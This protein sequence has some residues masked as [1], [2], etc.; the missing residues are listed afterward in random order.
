MAFDDLS[1]RQFGDLL[2]VLDDGRDARGA[3]KWLCLCKC[4]TQVSVWAQSLRS[5]RTSRCRNCR[6]ANWNKGGH[7][8]KQGYHVRYTEGRGQ[9]MVHVL[10][11]EE[12]LGRR[13]LPGENVHH[14]NGVKDDNRP[15]NLELWVSHQPA[16]QRPEDL[17]AWAKE[18]LERYDA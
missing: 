2:V 10:V 8:T 3:V 1:G 12:L 14:K 4:G 5:G 16:G 11:M 7:V 17:V 9:V 13:L 18:I 6:Y 15:E